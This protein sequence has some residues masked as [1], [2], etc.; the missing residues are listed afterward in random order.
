MKQHWFKAELQFLCPSCSK[1]S[2]ETILARAS[3]ENTAAIA[4]VERVPIE[5]QLCKVTCPGPV[6]IKILMS[7]TPEELANLQVGPSPTQ[8]AT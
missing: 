6:Q 2:T 3:D 5:C 7:L 8:L 1:V 4:I